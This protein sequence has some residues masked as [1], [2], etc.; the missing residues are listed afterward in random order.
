ML[1]DVRADWCPTC[2]AQKPLIEAAMRQSAYRDVTTL[3]IDFD[4]AGEL[5]RRYKV[6][7][8]STLIA[9]KGGREVG[10]TVGDTTAAGITGLLDRTVH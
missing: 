8:Q 2:R 3:T 9:F 4:H 1:L 10:R 6:V 7:M 5:L